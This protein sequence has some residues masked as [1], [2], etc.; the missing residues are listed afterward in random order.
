MTD[1]TAQSPTTVSSFMKKRSVIGI[2][3][4]IIIILLFGVYYATSISYNN[5]KEKLLEETAID[6][7]S[8]V[9]G[10]VQSIDIWSKSLDEEAQRVSTSDFYRIFLQD[11]VSADLSTIAN[12]LDSSTP[13]KRK[14]SSTA[15]ETLVGETGIEGSLNSNI[16][17]PAVETNNEAGLNF[18]F[19]FSTDEE[20]KE[21]DELELFSAQLPLVRNT[22]YDYIN[23]NGFTDARFADKNGATLLSAMQRPAALT[24]PQLKTIK[25]AIEQNAITFAPIR[26]SSAGLILDFA[27]PVLPL[28]VQ[29][30]SE[31]IAALMF[32]MP[33]L[34]QMAQFMGRDLRTDNSYVPQIMQYAEDHYQLLS[35]N[36]PEPV[37]IESALELDS[38]TFG[39]HFASRMSVDGKSAVYSYGR[40]VSN[41]DTWVILEVP[42]TVLED[43]FKSLAWTIYGLGFLIAVGILLLLA[44]LWWVMIGNEQRAVADKFKNLYHLLAQQKNLLDS[45]NMS[46]QVGLILVDG[47]GKIPIFNKAFAELV[48][49][50]EEDLEDVSLMTVFPGQVAGA[51]MEHIHHIQDE[52]TSRTFEVE[53]PAD[54]GENLLY[55]VTIYPV[56]DADDESQI[57]G[58]VATFQDITAFRRNSE[59]NKKQ[60]ESI[61]RTFTRAV[62]S[63]D[64]YLTGHSQMMSN[65]GVLICKELKLS[66][67]DQKIVKDAALF[68]QLGKLFI[69]RE[70]LNKTDKLTPEESAILR[71]IPD[72]AYEVLSSTGFSS[73]IAQAVREMNEQIDGLGYP[74]QL[75]GDQISV[76][77][78]ILAITNAFC[79]MISARSF[80][81]GLSYIEALNRLKAEPNRFDSYV[82][83]S[84]TAVLQTQEAVTALS[85]NEEQ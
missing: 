23:Y 45:I 65:L 52:A 49:R 78:K 50:A 26:S 58:A 5:S 42:A 24:A 4:G 32:T 43:K 38:D 6:L 9:N 8:W 10:T 69:P 48:D 71:Q 3:L 21:E 36:S 25:K 54:N 19:S 7:A 37:A 34:G 84:L 70:I 67:E 62:E 30:T 74:Q 73:Q 28:F 82:V 51:I 79:A 57:Q 17:T 2:S 14:S 11:I 59:K 39:L 81:N 16:H 77:A 47:H 1:N 80:R 75:R 85:P 44:L 41:M 35:V 31:P 40:K 61:I 15:P 63:I 20:N 64:P 12:S 66:E 83:D 60:Q 18:D 33:V 27:V 72:K 13:M 56:Q 29:N 55:R 22:L 53:I 76:H 68:S 46:L